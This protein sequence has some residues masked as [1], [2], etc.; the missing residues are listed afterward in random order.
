MR[1]CG[2]AAKKGGE[3]T[4]PAFGRILDLPGNPYSALL[5]I[6]GYDDESLDVLFKRRGFGGPGGPGRRHGA[7]QIVCNE[8]LG[9]PLRTASLWYVVAARLKCP[10]FSKVE[11]SRWIPLQPFRSATLGMSTGAEASPRPYR[12]GRV[13]RLA[14]CNRMSSNAPFRLLAKRSR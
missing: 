1:L 5:D 9:S 6:H 13:A 10:P 3:K 11:M 14:G 4:E 12:L 8:D 7:G 2:R